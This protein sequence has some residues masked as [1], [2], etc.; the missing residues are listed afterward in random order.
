MPRRKYELLSNGAVT[1]V[2]LLFVGPVVVVVVAAAVVVVVVA[3]VVPVVVD[4]DVDRN[5]AIA[6]E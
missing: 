2:L 6:F 1:D 4:G 3:V 5:V